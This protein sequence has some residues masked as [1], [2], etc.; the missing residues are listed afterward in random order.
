MPA[1]DLSKALDPAIWPL[2][3]KVREFIHYARKRQVGGQ[4]QVSQDQVRAPLTQGGRPASG[5]GPHLQVPGI[6]VE[7]LF[8]ALAGLEAARL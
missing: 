1:A 7:N 8:G 4:P 3:V 5:H 6:R 2:R